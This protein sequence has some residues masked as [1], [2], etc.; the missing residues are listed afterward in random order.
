MPPP[1]ETRMVKTTLGLKEETWLAA[2]RR[3]LDERRS[4]TQLV[5]E[6]IKAYL[7]TPKKEPK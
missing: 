4:L 2:K 3:A 6:A 1:K 7:K 5:E